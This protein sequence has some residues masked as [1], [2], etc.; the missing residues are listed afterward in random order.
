MES[1]K[2]TLGVGAEK[3]AEEIQ[4]NTQKEMS[5]VFDFIY[6]HSSQKEVYEWLRNLQFK[7]WDEDDYQFY[8]DKRYY[9]NSFK[10]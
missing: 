5:Q 10:G 7:A 6:N 4:I 3:I 8:V 2:N 9:M 1:F